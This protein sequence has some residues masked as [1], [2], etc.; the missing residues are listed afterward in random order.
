MIDSKRLTNWYN[1]QAPIYHFWRDDYQTPLISD[2]L[3]LVAANAEPK[4][5]LDV[6]CGSGLLAIG[7]AL[8]HSNWKIYGVDPAVGLLKIAHR[9]G[10]K[11][12]LSNTLTFS[13]G[14]VSAL[15]F[16]DNR[17]DV[18][19]AAGMFPNIND[20]ASALQ[21]IKRVLKPDGT[22]A[23]VE[24]DRTKMSQA[25]R[26][27]FKVM[28]FGYQVITTLFPRFRFAGRWNIETSTIDQE[29]F[30]VTAREIGLTVASVKSSGNQMIILCHKKSS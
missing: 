11:R 30:L 19:M 17:F 4:E 3:E 2:I 27:F 8:Q 24:F 22:L 18:V 25:D 1:F 20:H 14:T 7:L 15:E 28:I 13:E 12:S 9:E 16:P 29:P 26:L 10:N 6:G 21:E 23:I 5:V